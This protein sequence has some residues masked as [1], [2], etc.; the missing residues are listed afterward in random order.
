MSDTVDILQSCQVEEDDGLA[1]DE[2]EDYDYE[3]GDYLEDGEEEDYGF[4]DLEENLEET[5]FSEANGAPPP[6]SPDQKDPNYWNNYDD[7]NLS[8]Y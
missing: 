7:L 6:P 8:E 5:H 4:F 2:G 1:F 3:E